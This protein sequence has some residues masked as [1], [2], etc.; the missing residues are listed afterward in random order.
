MRPIIDETYRMG[1]S[2]AQHDVLKQ[3]YLD[4]ACAPAAAPTWR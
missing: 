1:G 3:L 4:C 2:H